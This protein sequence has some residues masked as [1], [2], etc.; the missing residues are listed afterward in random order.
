MEAI[1]INSSIHDDLFEAR[2]VLAIEAQALEAL[3]VSLKEQFSTAVDLILNTKGRVILTGMG[4]SGHVAHKI[5]A[6]F[7]STGTPSY[8]VHPAEASHGDLGMIADQDLIVALSNSGETSELSDILAYAKRYKIPLIGL[9]TNPQSTLAQTAHVALT[10]P[11]VEEACPL[12]LAPTTSSTMMMALGD[13]LA[14]AVLKRRGF[15]AADFGSLHPGGKL[16]QKLLRVEKL[17]HKGKSIPLTRV[18]TLMQDALIEMTSKGFGCVGVLDQHDRLLGVITDGDLRRHISANLLE[19]KVEE[20][21]TQDPFV[22]RADMLAHEA[23]AILNERAITNL[24]IVDLNDPKKIAGIIHVHDC[25][26][27]GLA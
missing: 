11:K 15:S 12:G 5:A 24:F 13:A 26:R 8:F 10:L 21:M 16:G 27:A 19:K 3:A 22:I 9:T 20:I 1:K 18:G 7:A 4:K 6:T 14:T 25:L 17:M 23:L 2:R